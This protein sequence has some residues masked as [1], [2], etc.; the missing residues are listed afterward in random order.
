MRNQEV[1]N[2]QLHFQIVHLDVKF[3]DIS[4]KK[5]VAKKSGNMEDYSFISIVEMRL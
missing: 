1:E 3:S 4:K 5:T 2:L